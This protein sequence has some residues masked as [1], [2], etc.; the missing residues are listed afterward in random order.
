MQPVRVP[1]PWNRVL[2]LGKIPKLQSLLTNALH[3]PLPPPRTCNPLLVYLLQSCRNS[4]DF[5]DGAAQS[6]NVVVPVQD[7]Q[8]GQSSG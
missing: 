6:L 4:N 8:A 2:D 5:L 1:D 3:T 7:L